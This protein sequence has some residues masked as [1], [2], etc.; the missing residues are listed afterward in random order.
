MA[1]YGSLGDLGFTADVPDVRGA[2][3]YGSEDEK[4]GNIEDV[5]FDHETMEIRF[6]VIEG[7]DSSRSHK[8]LFPVNRIFDDNKHRDGFVIGITKQKSEDFPDFDKRS[9]ESKESWKM[10]LDEFNKFWEEDPVMHRRGSDRIVTPTS[11]ELRASGNLSDSD[12]DVG[13]ASGD[14]EFSASKLFLS[15]F[16]TCSPTPHRAHIK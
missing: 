8:F 15:G 9:L 12:A 10:Y 2:D 13:E 4:I 11:E 5:I 7:G 3:V 6:V 14:L 1:H 16:Q